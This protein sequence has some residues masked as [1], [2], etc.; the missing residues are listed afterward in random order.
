MRR[1]RRT[2]VRTAITCTRVLDGTGAPPLRDG[3]VVVE[4]GRVA[5]IGPAASANFAG[6]EVIEA[7][8][9][10]LLPGLL[11]SH[12]HVYGYHTRRSP[13]TGSPEE[14]ARDVLD[15]VRGLSELARSGVV[16]VRDCGYPDHSVYALREGAAAGLFPLSLIHI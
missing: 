4:H 9:R 1:A 7:G 15:A 14:V 2:D 10:T 6:A 3:A 13:A 16:A 5:A 11:D 12:V 8:D